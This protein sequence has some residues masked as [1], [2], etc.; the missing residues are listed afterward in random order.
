MGIFK[1]SIL[2]PVTDT[3]LPFFNDKKG[4]LYIPLKT[5]YRYYI[6]AVIADQDGNTTYYLLLGKTKFDSN[7]RLCHTDDYGRVQIKVKSGEF[8]DYI[9][10]ESKERGNIIIEYIESN[11]D[12]DVY[13]VE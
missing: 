10:S 4:I 11:T 13:S 7:C 1:Y 2:H 5:I 12:Y 3:K 8:R 6:E 9:Y